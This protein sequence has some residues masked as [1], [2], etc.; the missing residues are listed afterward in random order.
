MLEAGDALHG[1]SVHFVTAV[2]DG[3]PV[4]MQ[5]QVEITDGDSAESL[6]ARLLPQEHRL[7]LASVRLFAERRVRLMNERIEL[8]GQIMI[9]PLVLTDD[10]DVFS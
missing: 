2:L 5:V 10:A 8:D 7:L 1:A 4:L 6:A 9:E 3:G